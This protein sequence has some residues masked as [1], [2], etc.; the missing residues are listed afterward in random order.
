MISALFFTEKAA[1]HLSSQP[2]HSLGQFGQ[3]EDGS[4]KI[5]LSREEAAQ[6]T[7]STLF[8]V[9]RMLSQHEA[10]VLDEKLNGIETVRPAKTSLGKSVGSL[11]SVI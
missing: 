2:I 7:G 1:A 4:A 3:P 10:L 6:L 9:I 11:F 8:S 5:S